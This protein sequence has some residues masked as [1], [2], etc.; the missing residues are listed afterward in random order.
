[1]AETRLVEQPTDWGRAFIHNHRT[2]AEEESS[3]PGL[4]PNAWPSLQT[5]TDLKGT[6]ARTATQGRLKR[7]GANMF[8]IRPWIKG[9]ADATINTISIYYYPFEG[10]FQTGKGDLIATLVTTFGHDCASVKNP[11]GGSVSYEAGAIA[12]NWYGGSFINTAAGGHYIKD[13]KICEIIGNPVADDGNLIRIRMDRLDCD[14]IYCRW[15]DFAAA[16]V[17]EGLFEVFFGS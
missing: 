3:A 8:I 17:S 11:V 14:S 13:S 1:M 16:N 15:E 12:A 7:N 2:L 5:L 6:Y 9:T 4:V 10:P